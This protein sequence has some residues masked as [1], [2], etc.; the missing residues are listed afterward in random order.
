MNEEAE[1]LQMKIDEMD[2]MIP[3]VEFNR[4]HRFGDL[5]L[6]KGATRAGTVV[7]LTESHLASVPVHIYDKLFKKNEQVKIQNVVKFLR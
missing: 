2:K 1:D 7:A 4:N 3:K 5:S 6:L